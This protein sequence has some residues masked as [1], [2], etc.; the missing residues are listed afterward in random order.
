[1][2][3][4]ALRSQGT[5]HRTPISPSDRLEKNMQTFLKTFAVLGLTALVAACGGRDTQDDVVVIQPTV[6]PEPI[7]GKF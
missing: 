1:V 2:H 4:V 3:N 5:N 7:S 6:E